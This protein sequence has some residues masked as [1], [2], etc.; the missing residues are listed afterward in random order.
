VGARSLWKHS[1][2]PLR[3]E[4][5]AMSLTRWRPDIGSFIPHACS[6]GCAPRWLIECLGLG[7]GGAMRAVRMHMCIDSW[8]VANAAYIHACIRTYIHTYVHTHTHTYIQRYH[9]PWGLLT[10]DTILPGRYLQRMQRESASDHLR[11]S[12]Q[13]NFRWMGL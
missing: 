11:H 1:Q 5:F 4:A 3:V 10:I 9:S 6:V 2:C 12:L 7:R 13:W 8:P